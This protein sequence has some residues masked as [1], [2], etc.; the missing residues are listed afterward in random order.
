MGHHHEPGEI[1]VPD[2]LSGVLRP[3]G[4]PTADVVR[5][6]AATIGLQLAFDTARRPVSCPGR[7]PQCKLTSCSY[8]VT[9]A[10]P[11]M[12]RGSAQ[13][14]VK[15]GGNPGRDGHGNHSRG[16]QT[17]RSSASGRPSTMRTSRH[18]GTTVQSLPG[19]PP[20]FTRSSLRDR[21]RSAFPETWAAC[22]AAYQGR[23]PPAGPL[24]H[25]GPCV[26]IVRPAISAL[27]K[28]AHRQRALP[29]LAAISLPRERPP[30]I[31][32]ARAP[33]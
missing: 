12:A 27:V 14:Q 2:R 16:T 32:A 7:R 8:A 21:P 24:F 23:S 18:R 22:S 28:P 6:L 31:A 1:M 19:R 4:W 20:V 15:P 30:H 9:P 29:I 13:A 33:P 3:P 5:S 10:A 11:G 26:R 25:A 17:H